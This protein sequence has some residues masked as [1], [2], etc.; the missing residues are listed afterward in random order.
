MSTLLRR[1]ASKVAIVVLV[2][3][4]LATGVAVV[5]SSGAGTAYPPVDHQLCYAAYGPY[6]KV[7][8]HV[9]LIN[10]FVPNGFRPKIIINTVVL[11]CNPVIKFTQNQVFD[12]TNPDAH[13]A[14]YPMSASTQATHKVIV[15]NQFGQALLQTGQPKQLCLPSWKGLKGPPRKSPR[16]PPGLNH[17]TCYPVTVID[18]TYQPPPIMLKDE[19]SA[20]PVAVQVNPVPVKLCLPTEK[21]VTTAAGV[22]DFPIINPDLHLLCY[23]VTPTPKK[24]PVWDENQFGT[25]KVAIKITK[26]LCLPSTK[27]VIQ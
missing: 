10:Q 15:G 17:F 22:K 23:P 26:V 6:Y 7:P 5:P 18:G 19:F 13:L 4:C 9:S 12:V 21:V 1:R 20:Q 3:L 24:T 2:G 25:N 11:H 14:C 8:P 16:T 27:Q